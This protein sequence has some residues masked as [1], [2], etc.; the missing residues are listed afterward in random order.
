MLLRKRPPDVDIK[1][2]INNERITRV[3]VTKVLGIFIDDD[4]NWKHHIN[5]VRKKIVESCSDHL[6]SKLS[7]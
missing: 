4:L 7:N 6:Q 1:L 3:H 2:C 5:T